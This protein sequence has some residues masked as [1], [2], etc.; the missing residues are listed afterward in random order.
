MD[1]YINKPQINIFDGISTSRTMGSRGIPDF[2]MPK[3]N[4]A[5]VLAK[6]LL[7]LH[8]K[9]DDRFKTDIQLNGKTRFEESNTII[10][11]LEEEI[12]SMKHKLSFV[13]EKDEEIGKLNFTFNESPGQ[14]SKFGLLV[15]PLGPEN[16][17]SSS[18]IPGY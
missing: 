11:S 9:K 5:S 8:N 15:K 13:Y 6:D 1:G 17:K 18:I 4:D 10:K 12:V 16:K 3:K 7:P 14:V 2:S